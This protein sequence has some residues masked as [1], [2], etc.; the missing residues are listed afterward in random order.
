MSDLE[1][2]G[3]NDWSAVAAKF[4]EYTHVAHRPQRD[5][6]SVKMKFDRLANVKKPTGDPSCPPNVRRAEHIA[7]S[8]LGKVNAISM[9]D[10]S[11][12]DSDGEIMDLVGSS[13]VGEETSATHIKAGKGRVLGGSKGRRKPGAGGLKV[14]GREYIVEPVGNMADSVSMLVDV[15][16]KP[17]D[18]SE[19]SFSGSDLHESIRNS[20]KAEVTAELAHTN[21]SIE[22]LKTLVLASLRR[23]PAA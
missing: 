18:S 20:I 2:I 9:G 19:S 13:S 5:V 17:Q 11:S 23:G 14:R 12:S 6:E 1:P 7:R 3:G 21:A 10:E 8:I 15:L 4:R 22:E 16:R